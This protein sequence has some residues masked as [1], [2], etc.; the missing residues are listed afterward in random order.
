MTKYDPDSLKPRGTLPDGVVDLLPPFGF[1]AQW[2]VNNP[3]RYISCDGW[4]I[5]IPE[6]FL[7]DLASIPRILRSIF[8]VNARES[9]AAV[10]HDFGYRHKRTMLFNVI[11]EEC[12][13]L[14]RKE[15]D[16]ILRDVMILGQT[17][18]IRWQAIYAGVRAGGWWTWRKR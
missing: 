16:L 18:R 13:S 10:I 17:K 6:G 5:I 11:T 9:T 12:R 8:G 2:K 3:F 1:R 15:W 7:T 4:Y 14:K